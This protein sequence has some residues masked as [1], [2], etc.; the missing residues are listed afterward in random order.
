MGGFGELS[1]GC[2][3]LDGRRGHRQRLILLLVECVLGLSIG[4]ERILPRALG[5]VELVGGRRLR[6]LRVLGVAIGLERVLER[7][8]LLLQRV[9]SLLEIF[10][11]GSGGVGG[12]IELGAGIAQRRV[13][14]N[15]V[16][17]EQQVAGLHMLIG[18]HIDVDHGATHLRGH[19]DDIRSS[20]GVLG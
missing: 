20:I 6:R 14:E 10:A 3:E 16:D 9:R 11:G 1:R 5:G 2:S 13:I 12:G 7:G 18:V 17:V 19:P 8:A 4:L 15:G